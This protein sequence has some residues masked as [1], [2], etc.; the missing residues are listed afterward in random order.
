MTKAAKYTLITVSVYYLI[1]LVFIIALGD[2]QANAHL[3][4]LTNNLPGSFLSWVGHVFFRFVLLALIWPANVGL[5][6][7]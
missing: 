1:G 6:L 4:E 3:H 7:M 2:D 5:L